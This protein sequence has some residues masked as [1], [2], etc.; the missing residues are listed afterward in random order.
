MTLR[1]LG[2]PKGK[3]LC[4]AHP[5]DDHHVPDIRCGCFS[6]VL[7]AFLAEALG[8]LGVSASEFLN[9]LDLQRL[10]V[11]FHLLLLHQCQ[12]RPSGDVPMAKAFCLRGCGFPEHGSDAQERRVGDTDLNSGETLSRLLLIGL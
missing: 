4:R 6:H 2:R 11:A 12:V 10:Q 7:T 9:F 1:P 5:A 3:Q 8:V